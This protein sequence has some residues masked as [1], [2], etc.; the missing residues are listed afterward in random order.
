MTMPFPEPLD[1]PPALEKETPLWRYAVACWQQPELASACLQL[2]AQGWSVI[3]ILCA[4]WLGATGRRFSGIED[5]KV[6]EWR[7]RVTG[8]LR[9]ARK[10]IPADI[11]RYR[12][13]RDTLS[14]VELEAEQTELALAWQTLRERNP[15]ASDMQDRKAATRTNLL[16]A[17]PSS[18]PVDAGTEDLITV[19][20]QRLANGPA[21]DLEPC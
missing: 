9:R 17:A 1:L 8:N 3:R 18:S 20:A 5:A 4:G 11:P 14:E 10:S 16:A 19:L 21:E 2:Q 7:S 13:L 15:E 6:T 12:G